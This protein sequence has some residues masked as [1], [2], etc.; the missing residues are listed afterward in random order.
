MYIVLFILL[1]PACVSFA[2]GYDYATA[3]ANFGDPVRGIGNDILSCPQVLA[4]PASAPLTPALPAA[5]LLTI[6]GF[7][8]VSFVR[9]RATWLSILICFAALA[10]P[11]QIARKIAQP[12]V[13]ATKKACEPSVSSGLPASLAPTSPKISL[14]Y[15]GLLYRLTAGD[16]IAKILSQAKCF[17]LQIE[18]PFAF[19]INYFALSI[20]RSF[21]VHQLPRGPPQFH[22]RL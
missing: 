15:A 11:H 18:S 22:L 9:D 13:A 4:Q 2:G 19:C 6:A 17:Q 12:I 5:I 16:A 10:L 21:V 8:C 7:A 20:Q 14:D 3:H 1:A